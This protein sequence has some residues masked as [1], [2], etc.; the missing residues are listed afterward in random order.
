[1]P[2]ETLQKNTGHTDSRTT[3][4]YSKAQLDRQLADFESAFGAE[5][6]PRRYG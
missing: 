4:R 2:I 6:L 5:R 1:M 3:M